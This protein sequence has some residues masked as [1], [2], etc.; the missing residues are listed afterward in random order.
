MRFGEA[1]MPSNRSYSLVLI[2]DK[3]QVKGI[4]LVVR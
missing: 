4:K 2:E 1:V 3:R